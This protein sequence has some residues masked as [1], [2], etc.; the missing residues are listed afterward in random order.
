LFLGRLRLLALR[1]LR[2]A[3]LAR[4]SAARTALASALTRL[5]AALARLTGSRLP[6]LPPA[7]LLT[8]ARLAAAA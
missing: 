3:W 8:A 6:A 1:H 5:P 4:L 2:V 7:R